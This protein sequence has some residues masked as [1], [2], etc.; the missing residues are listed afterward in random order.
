MH[1]IKRISIEGYRRLASVKDVEMRPLTVLIGPNNVGKTSFL[2]VLSLLAA[3]AVGQ[4]S[5]KITE[6]G[7]ITSMLTRGTASEFTVDLQ[8][9]QSP[10][11]SLLYHL[12]L[13]PAGQTYEVAEETL[14]QES[15]RPS[16][17]KHIDSRP[18]NIHYFDPQTQRLVR[19]NW[20]HDPLESSLSQVPKMYQQAE[21][22]R[23][24]LA[25]LAYY[26]SLDLDVSRKSPLRLPQQ[27]RPA[28][29]PG[30][31]GEQLVSCLY[32]L[33]ETNRERF[34]MIQET[35][36]SA[37]PGF[38][39]MDFPPVAAG[40]L[41]LTW[42]E[43]HFPT[44][45]YMHELSEGTIRFLWLVT[46]LQSPGLT[47]IT[48]IDEPE[49][50]LHPDLLRLLVDLLRE[51]SSRTQ[52]VVATHSDRL[53]RFLKPAEVLVCDCEDGNTAMRWGD[54]FELDKWLEDYGL[55]ELWRMGRLGA[56]S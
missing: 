33:R 28:T 47:E 26:A 23:K 6:F 39:R 8:A 18:A 31:A 44:P 7:G 9:D 49:V 10:N 46:L 19:P 54:S 25:S 51:A 3:S 4:M 2:D 56:R 29:L 15:D 43:R 5:Q 50:S 20:E 1:E 42:K 55:D 12:S 41:A 16:P 35:L 24:R 48:L 14:T 36:T 22:F 21:T 53:V 38:E 30:P 11:P 34:D 27:M 40:T 32:C 45:I 52:L 37:F 17:F 13:R